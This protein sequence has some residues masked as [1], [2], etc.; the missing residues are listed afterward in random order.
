MKQEEMNVAMSGKSTQH[1]KVTGRQPSQPEKREPLRQID[2][3]RIRLEIRARTPNP[4]SR[5]RHTYTRAKPPPKLSLPSGPCR[6]P[7]IITGRPSPNELRP[8]NR[9]P[10]IE[11][12]EMPNGGESPSAPS[13][14]SGVI[15]IA[16]TGPTKM[17]SKSGKPRLIET[18]INNLKKRP[19]STLG[20]PRVPLR[21]NPRS[22]SDPVADQAPRGR[23]L[24]VG[25]DT[26]G[27]AIAG[28]K[29]R[30]HPLGQPPLHAAGRHGD[31]L[32]RE[33]IRERIGEQSAKR[34]D[35]AVGP[36]C[37]VCLKH[38]EGTGGTCEAA[39]LGAKC[40]RLLRD[41]AYGK[42][43]T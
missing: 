35:Q 25:A 3:R 22:S 4:L 2:Q 38:G 19:D 16:L 31:Q 41:A 14:L 23:K 1:L 40:P 27:A 33:W 18:P 36:F 12:G 24:N 21:I 5:I 13:S 42:E 26:I 37:S 29:S 17:S 32:E 20:K 43:A 11:V 10:V 15:S 8:M 28:T 9:I 39:L 34:P 7:T 30:G 6:Y